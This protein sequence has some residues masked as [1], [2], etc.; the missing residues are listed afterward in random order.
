[1]SY[2]F[3]EQE[4]AHLRNV[5]G[6]L[7]HVA[8]CTRACEG[9][10]MPGLSYWRARVRPILATSSLPTHLE[11]Q[12]KDLLG[13]LARLEDLQHR[14]RTSGTGQPNRPAH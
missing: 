8:D 11:K 13:R 10:S 5:V 3:A 12:A 7:E 1:M 6:H 9:G 4:L 14:A 2:D